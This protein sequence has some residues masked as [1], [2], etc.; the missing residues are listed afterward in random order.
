MARAELQGLVADVRRLLDEGGRGAAN[1]A[2][3]RRRAETLRTLAAQVPALA[4]VAGAAQAVVGAQGG[5]AVKALCD[6]LVL[7]RQV[8]ASLTTCGIA[9]PLEPIEKSGP[10]QTAAPLHD[11]NRWAE[12]S[13]T[14]Y[15]TGNNT[16]KEDVNR[17][18]YPD[19]RLVDP[20]LRK[21][22]SSPGYDDEDLLADV[23]LPR[24][25]P[26]ILPELQR[27]LKMKGNVEASRRL[28]AI[29]HLD[30][31]VGKELSR[32][33]L[34]EGSPALKMEAIRAL[35]TLAPAEAE[36]A[37]IEVLGGKPRWDMAHVAL[38]ALANS[39]SDKALDALM[40]ALFHEEYFMQER[41]QEVLQKIPH[42]QATERLLAALDERLQAEKALAAEKLKKKPAA[43][44]PAKGKGKAAAPGPTL[45]E[46]REQIVRVINVLGGRGDS[47]ATPPLLN[48]LKH[49]NVEVREQ[50]LDALADIGDPAGLEAAVPFLDHKTLWPYAINAVWKMPGKQRYEW[51]APLIEELSKPKKADHKRGKHILELFEQE[52][53]S[54]TDE[55]EDD[56]DDDEDDYRPPAQP[57]SDWDKRWADLLRPHLKGPYRAEAAIALAAVLGKAAG[58]EL[59]PHLVPSVKKNECGVVEALGY[60]GAREAIPPMIDL[61][62]GQPI[63]HYCIHNALRA[64]GDPSAIPL[65]EKIKDRMKEVYRHEQIDAV[66]KYLEKHAAPPGQ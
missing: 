18:D 3:L 9:G 64:I 31:K 60:A 51:L 1:D 2:G 6:L 19:L 11:V 61:I 10:W 20:L 48:L 66:I 5:S 25:G 63:H 55:D 40:G 16:S 17:P 22:T 29:V 4:P 33:A 27:G 14:P 47:R 53:F 36:Q 24:F 39:K 41:A 15:S 8:D 30:T 62:P 59:L 12:S 26:T 21:L 23:A 58:P 42:A 38:G 49:P 13:Y 65:L 45:E 52:F 46:V 54:E 57:R 32:Q 56:F 43:K 28:R 44:A 35:Q 34:K 50:A 7:A 37:A